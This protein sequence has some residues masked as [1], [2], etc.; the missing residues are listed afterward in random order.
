VRNA[1]VEPVSTAGAV[2]GVLG[3]LVLALVSVMLIILSMHQ[4]TGGMP[5]PK[6]V[7][8]I[9]IGAAV[10]VLVVAS[11]VW[12]SPPAEPLIVVTPTTYGPPRDLL[13]GEPL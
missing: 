8:V 5:G 12:P 11:A 3:A 1:P 2:A 6:R 13:S 4:A 10:V 9:V 7:A